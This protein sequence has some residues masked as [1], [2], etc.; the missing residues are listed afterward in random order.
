LVESVLAI[1]QSQEPP[2]PATQLTESNEGLRELW[3]SAHCPKLHWA[4]TITCPESFATA[5]RV[6]AFVP[7]KKSEPWTLTDTPLVSSPGHCLR[8]SAKTSPTQPPV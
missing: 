3:T 5:S 4:G 6:R 8:A 1:V 7:V 2:A